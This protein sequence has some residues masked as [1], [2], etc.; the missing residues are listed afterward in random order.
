M[1][2]NPLRLGIAG[3]GTVGCGVIRILQNQANML[4]KRAARPL[5]ISAISARDRTKIRPVDCSAYTWVND[6]ITLAQHPAIDVFIEVMGGEGEPAKT[7]TLTALH[8]GKHVV[9]ANKALLAHCGQDIAVLSEQQKRALRFEAAVGGGM[10]VIKTLS[11]ALAAN[12]IN[13]VIGILNGTCNYILTRMEQAQLD[14]A[15]ALAEASAKGY[16]EADPRL[17]IDGLDTGH[18]VALIAALAFGTV[19]NFANVRCQGI[20][21]ITLADSQHAAD[22][23]Y[24]IKLLGG[25]RKTDT[26]GEQWCAPCLV[27]IDSILGS[28]NGVM[29]IVQIDA[30]AAGTIILQG[31]GAGAAPTASAVL[32]DVLDIARIHQTTT[33]IGPAFGKTAQDLKTTPKTVSL[34]AAPYYIGLNVQ[35]HAGALHEITALFE[36]NAVSIKQMHQYKPKNKIAHVVIITHTIYEHKRNNIIDALNNSAVCTN[37]PTAFRIETNL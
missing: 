35:D 18:K 25:V 33:P 36:Q 22:M 3:L 15:D 7:A 5:V 8:A 31:A 11:E 14:Y 12:Q 13:S 21:H 10:P 34:S 16:L 6:P 27:P 2:L 17:D 37:A 30:N 1:T 23:G 19:P 4:A 20:G 28:V 32:A 9:S 29:N 24:R 26:G